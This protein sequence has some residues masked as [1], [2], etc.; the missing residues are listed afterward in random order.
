MVQIILSILRDLAIFMV[1][2]GIFAYGGG[3]LGIYLY[4]KSPYGGT[5]ADGGYSAFAIIGGVIGIVVGLTV[6]YFL[7]SLF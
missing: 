1:T 5:S 6:G 7:A 2:I 4:G 3:Y